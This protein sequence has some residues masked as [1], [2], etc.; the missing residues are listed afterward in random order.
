[1]LKI[2]NTS[3]VPP[4]GYR[5]T[6]PDTGATFGRPTYAQII[7]LIHNHR[8]GN[9]LPNL[10]MDQIHHYLC[11]H[12]AEGVCN[13]SPEPPPNT[14][15]QDAVTLSGSDAHRGMKVI[16]SFWKAGRKTVELEEA[17]A[18]ARTCSKCPMNVEYTGGCEAC[19]NGLAK[20]VKTI[21][22]GK[23]KTT[24]EDNLK[25][26]AICHCMNAAQV[27]VPYEH[28]KHGMTPSMEWPDECWKNPK[29][30]G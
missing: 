17:E 18:R 14:K 5:Y 13:G 3:R 16:Y 21:T 10:N 1:M 2:N 15:E 24:V 30:N 26:C 8:K 22:A 6:D 27:W 7:G 20:M 9:G 28:L 11:Q 12:A 29:N 19:R 4:G 23:K 25:A